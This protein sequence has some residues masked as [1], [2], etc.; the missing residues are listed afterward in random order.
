MYIPPK[1][2]E[3]PNWVVWKYDEEGKKI[4]HN[5]HTGGR[6]QS[7]NASTWS[8][9]DTALWA[10]RE[11]GWNGLGIMLGGGLVGIDFDKV[12]DRVSGVVKPWV[13]RYIE[14]FDSYTEVSPSETGIHI[15]VFGELPD[16]WRK[17]PGTEVYD[18]DRYFTFTGEPVFSYDKDV[19]ERSGP[20][21][22]F[23]DEVARDTVVLAR[24]TS[25]RNADAISR[26]WD[27]DTSGYDHDHSAADLAMCYHLARLTQGDRGQMLRLFYRS[28]LFRA[29]WEEV[30]DSY[31]NTYG[32]MTVDK[33]VKSWEEDEAAAAAVRGYEPVE[34]TEDQEQSI[35]QTN[36][37]DGGMAE[38]FALLFGD[39]FR[40][41]HTN[42]KW[43]VW[44]RTIWAPDTRGLTRKAM[45]R[46]ARAVAIMGVNRTD[47]DLVR[48]GMKYDNELHVG[49][50]LSAATHH[51][52]FATVADDYD[53]DPWLVATHNGVIDLRTGVF[54]EALREDMLTMRLGATYDAAARAPRWEQFL[55]EVFGNDTQ[56]IDY[57][58]RAVG[59]TLTGDTGEHKMFLLHGAGANG[60]S[61]FLEVI[62]ALLG[63]YSATAALNTFDEKHGDATNDLAALAGR[64]F[65][66]IT[67]REEDKRIAEAR[68]KTVTGQDPVTCRFLYGEYFTYLPVFKVWLAMNHL[69]TIK[70]TD[71]G[72]WRRI[73]LVPFEESFTGEKA[74][75]QLGYK[76]R[77][78]LS[79]ILNWALEGLVAWKQHGLKTPDKVSEATTAY[80]DDMDTVIQWM[81]EMLTKEPGAVTPTADL[82]DSFRAWCG[83]MGIREISSNAF[84][85]RLKEKGLEQGRTGKGARAYLG[86][87]LGQGGETEEGGGG[88]NFYQ[89]SLVE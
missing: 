1:L 78:E 88:F 67:E 14:T 11:G 22:A 54:R 13:E 43:L 46:A 57:V 3:L 19:E 49:N 58:Q 81:S 86:V 38:V 80:R 34:L 84:G 76:L 87:K 2:R 4:P 53:Q 33:A 9:F 70:G 68:V 28:G 82:Y 16:G 66:T 77:V 85:R 60:K 75:K 36:H 10:K 32:E 44:D 27:G 37:T 8:D 15:L 31:G 41:N 69:P 89:A 74:D 51:S 23:H 26:L 79:G 40:Y 59:Y 18:R 71:N 21:A 62:A 30:H 48:R 6:A 63:D 72:I 17:N 64:R 50:A 73:D 61:K 39:Y 35:I 29:K 56:M 12:R 45:H 52:V 24:L 5:P 65:V 47:E 83:R 7:N 25:G 42:K 20:L 55:S